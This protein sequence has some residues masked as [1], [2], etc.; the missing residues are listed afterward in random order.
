MLF[1]FWA[2]FL[3]TLQN[4]F[5]SLGAKMLKTLIADFA[6]F[7]AAM[8]GLMLSPRFHYLCHFCAFR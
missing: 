6:A 5:S 2:E 3:S 4:V 1:R 8:I 7:R